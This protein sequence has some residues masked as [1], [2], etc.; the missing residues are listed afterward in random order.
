VSCTALHE[1]DCGIASTSGRSGDPPAPARAGRAH[2]ACA[3]GASCLQGAWAR[4][5]GRGGAAVAVARARVRRA[6][7]PHNR[8]CPPLPSPADAH[9]NH[10]LQSL[11]DDAVTVELQVDVDVEPVDESTLLQRR[12]KA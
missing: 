7:A 11:L 1:Q 4:G 9:N 3:C 5:P 8:A 10:K 2:A 6:C 12:I